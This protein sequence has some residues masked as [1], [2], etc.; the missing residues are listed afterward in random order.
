MLWND[1][2]IILRMQQ[3]DTEQQRRPFSPSLFCDRM[4]WYVY[5]PFV[6]FGST[7]SPSALS[8]VLRRRQEA[9]GHT[10]VH[11]WVSS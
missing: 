6:F 4:C 1:H 8:F 10:S 11:A 7:F 9:S 2:I 3:Y 5:V